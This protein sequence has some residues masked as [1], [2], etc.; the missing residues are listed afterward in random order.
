MITPQPPLVSP[1]FYV[2][3]GTVPGTAVSYVERQA[4]TDLYA[5]LL[6]GEFCNVLTARQMGK[7]SLMV[8]VATR[9]KEEGTHVALIDL[10]ALGINLRVE[11]WYEGMLTRIGRQLDR[12]DK[13]E[14]GWEAR[15]SLPPL[16]RW[17][18]VLEEVILPSLP[19]NLVLFIDEIDL[20]RSLPFT[21][22]EFFVGIRAC[23]NRRYQEPIFRRL[24]FCLLGV[25]RPAD[26]IQDRRI[27]PF[28]VGQ[29]IP[30]GDFTPSEAQSL[31]VGMDVCGKEGKRL[32]ARVLHWTGGHPYL[33][34]QL[35]QAVALS[36][37]ILSEQDVDAVCARLFFSRQ[38]WEENSNLS[39]VANRLLHYAREEET[40]QALDL[41]RRV[42]QGKSVSDDDTNP[43]VSLLKL[44]G[45]V[46]AQMGWLQVRNRIYAQVFDA[47]WIRENMP[48]AEQRR[49]KQAYWR[50]VLRTA[51]VGAICLS[52]A[53]SLLMVE[54]THLATERAHVNTLQ[55]LYLQ[56][57]R[58]NYAA[59]MYLL[60]KEWEAGHD[61]R[62]VQL[63]N[64]QSP[65]KGEEELRGWE[66]RYF[67]QQAHGERL[68]MRGHTGIVFG[69]D[70]SSDGRILASAG[71][72]NTVRLWDA[73]MGAQ[74]GLLARHTANVLAVKFSPD[75]HM[76]ASCGDDDTLRLWD[77]HTQRQI[78]KTM[79]GW[80]SVAFSPNGRTV[81]AT[82]KG[83]HPPVRLWDVTTQ[84]PV[85]SL[86]QTAQVFA[87]AFSPDG[88]TLATGGG[89]VI[90]RKEH[91]IRLWD[92]SAPARSPHSRSLVAHKSNIYSLAF[93]RDGRL[94]ATGSEDTTVRLWD[95]KTR[96][97]LHT[98]L[99]H[100]GVASAVKFSP[101][102]KTLATSSWDQT[103][104]LWDVQTGK[105]LAVLRGQPDMVTSVSFSPNGKRLATA[106][107]P[108]VRVWDLPVQPK[109]WQT[110]MNLPS[111]LSLALASDEQTLAVRDGSTRIVCRQ[112]PSGKKLPDLPIPS[113]DAQGHLLA[114]QSQA[115]SSDGTL[116]ATA[117]KNEIDLWNR[118]TWQKTT[119]R[120]D[121][122]GVLA[123]SHDSSQLA[124]NDLDKDEV[125]LW[126]THTGHRLSRWK[127]HQNDILT[128]VFSPD[129][130]W[131]VS[132][133]WDRTLTVWDMKSGLSDP[134][135]AQTLHGHETPIISVAF[136]PDSKTLVTTGQDKTIKFWQVPTFREMLSLPAPDQIR[137]LIFSKDGNTLISGGVNGGVYVWK[138]PS[139]QEIQ[140]R[141]A[142]R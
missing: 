115:F 125:S 14:E 137:T 98:L 74:I 32:L 124:T 142:Q 68:A 6:H 35:C 88:K 83:I 134:P 15:G 114:Y 103:T 138:V 77:V 52:L 121:H 119:L 141:E 126:D 19:G 31:A 50:G 59:D 120:G 64:A 100:N 55:K 2:T 37:H 63:L 84:K 92:V 43:V 47:S 107:R 136:S 118:H 12:E 18:A 116:F 111:L 139:L 56:E 26:L 57:R 44:S 5:Y 4:D 51:A 60:Q 53:G 122:F 135:L 80:N 91:V 39:F 21:T 34:Q 46:G 128:L 97:R 94:L 71:S 61:G 67:W 29:G 95:V 82:T 38:R 16:Q 30:L 129:G 130:K 40:A 23:Y 106:S 112:Y 28:N 73:Q 69:V 33:T 24:T 110:C 70:Y 86:P 3:G 108:E 131:L 10:T 20:V 58:F 81:A 89:E 76:L 101:D 102:D 17:L 133:S 54:R 85:L 72:D 25:A 87:L 99:G 7:S 9:L 105:P 8:R 79:E 22:D 49:Q 140:E 11:Q 104:R 62:A 96:R 42:R 1:S 109:T 45:I 65:N 113:R 66:W 93:S 90:N 127:A 13:V 123:L 48:D 41:Y 75:G 36:E 78:G 117:Q 27:T 132:G